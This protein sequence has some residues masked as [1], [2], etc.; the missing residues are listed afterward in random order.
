[1]EEYIFSPDSSLME[2]TPANPPVPEPQAVA[3][4]VP[5]APVIASE[6]EQTA[7]APVA[8]PPHNGMWMTL[9][10]MGVCISLLLGV[11]AIWASRNGADAFNLP[12]AD[13]PQSVTPSY[14][15]RTEV[16][17]DD[18]LTNQEIIK[19]MTPSVVT[20]SVQIS[21]QGQVGTGFGTGVIYTDNGYILTNAHVVENA[22]AVSVTDHEGKTYSAK[23]IGADSDTDTA[24]IK[25]DATDLIPA[26]FGQSSKTV[27]GDK[28]IAIGTPYAE[29][30]AYTATEGMVSALRDGMNFP[31]LGYTLDLIQHDAAINSGNSGGPLVNV[32]GQVIGINTIKISGT[33]ENLGF[34]LQIDEV[35]PIAEE[36]MKHG[37]VI[38]P[39]IGITGST[40]DSDGIKGTYIHSVVENGPAA[41]AGLRTGDIIV[42]AG[43]KEISSIYELKEM[44]NSC[45]I[46]DTISITY[47][48]GDTVHT[49]EMVLEELQAE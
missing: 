36:L 26:E 41:K 1:M 47:M 14:N 24:V 40:Y 34:A 37:K 7:P 15:Y 49:T 32:Y 28:V 11:F 44:I 22:T 17:E 9:A 16:S 8:K 30:L 5:V 43:D 48:R 6:P 33:Y 12:G 20:V 25:I 46:G 23:I 31:E 27:P 45:K 4:V 10:I 3:T 39:G 29:N 42:K 13:I 21:A 35:L 2:Q 38:R 19:K 18:I